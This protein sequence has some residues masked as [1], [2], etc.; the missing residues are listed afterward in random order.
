[1]ALKHP[2]STHEENNTIKAE[3][4]KTATD[5][6]DDKI[7]FWCP[8]CGQKYRLP[9][10]SAGETGICFKCQG[11]LLIPSKSQE[12]APSIKNIVF[13]CSHCGSKQRKARKHIGEEVKC[14]EC[15]EKNTVP[16]NQKDHHW[17]RK[18]MNQKN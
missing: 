13:P 17:R 3:N 16:E 2:D 5:S 12:K 8:E 11:Y 7:L 9:K 6:Q 15:G 18:A 4:T 10:D 1:M 14:S